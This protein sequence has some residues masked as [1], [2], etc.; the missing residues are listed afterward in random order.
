MKNCRYGLRR[1]TVAQAAA[2][3]YPHLLPAMGCAQLLYANLPHKQWEAVVHHARTPNPLVFAHVGHE[4]LRL[5]ASEEINLPLTSLGG[6]GVEHAFAL[7]K[8]WVS[9]GYTG[10]ALENRMTVLRYWARWVGNPSYAPA[11]RD[12]MRDLEEVCHG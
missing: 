2:R 6:F 8:Y 9:R 12:V 10:A 4:A 1:E 7:G 11:V 5:L 3:R